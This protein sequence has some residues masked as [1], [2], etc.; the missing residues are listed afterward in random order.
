MSSCSCLRLGL[1]LLSRQKGCQTLGVSGGTPEVSSR[2]LVFVERDVT[3][4]VKEGGVTAP[5]EVQRKRIRT[6]RNKRKF[7]LNLVLSFLATTTK[8]TPR[9]WRDLPLV[10]PS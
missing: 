4:E 3:V 9:D 2:G 5:G 8:T 10:L 7:S 6:T 1:C